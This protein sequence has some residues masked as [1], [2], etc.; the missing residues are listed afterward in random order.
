MHVSVVLQEKG[1]EVVTTGPRTALADIV[2]MLDENRIGAVVIVEDGQV[3]GVVAERDI[4]SALATHGPAALGLDAEDVMERDV[5]RC[6]PHTSVEYLMTVMTDRRVRHIPV[7]EAGVLAG[8]VSIG[9]VVKTRLA[10]LEFE[11]EA[12][13]SYI[14]NPY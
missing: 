7:E 11:A 4:I 2:S 5:F 12:L 9:D 13:Q 10:N 8:L 14:T 1:S 3:E 6:D